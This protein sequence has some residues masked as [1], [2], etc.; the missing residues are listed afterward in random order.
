MRCLI[1]LVVA[2]MMSHG[3]ADGE[4]AVGWR[5]DGTGL[6]PGARPPTNWTETEHVIWKAPTEAWSNASP[7][8]IAD[9]VFVLGERSTLLCLDVG[10][11]RVMWQA[12]NEYE[13]VL[14]PVEEIQAGLEEQKPEL[15]RELDALEQQ[16]AAFDATGRRAKRK[17]RR[18]KQQAEQ[19]REMIEGGQ[20]LELPSTHGDNGYSSA[21]P[22]SNGKHIWASFGTGTVVCYDV[23]GRRLWARLVEKPTHGWGHSASPKMI[24]GKLIVSVRDLFALDPLTGRTIWR[25]DSEQHWGTPAV[26]HIGEMGVILTTA[27][28]VVRAADGTVL[29]H[30]LPVMKW[31]GPHVVDG[32]VY[33]IEDNASAFEIPETVTEPLKLKELWS[34][35]VAGSRHYASPLVYNSFVYTISRESTMS[36]LDAETGQLV[37]ERTMELGKGNSVYTSL[38]MAGNL[39]YAGSMTGEIVLFKPGRQYKE[40]ARNQLEP[41]RSTPVFLGDRMYLRGLEYVYCLGRSEISLSE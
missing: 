26:T 5:T 20:L 30:D 15:E 3:I 34:T 38:S 7:V 22:L 4:V 40:V 37:Y 16:I 2:V 17:L 24:D 35:R 13:E 27:G 32:K 29:A 21:T 39:I 10:T 14:G 25:T 6:Y 31:N 1:A 9:R 8:V 12:S 19:L 41:F 11:G 28:Q 23:Y 36:V 33:F 18:I